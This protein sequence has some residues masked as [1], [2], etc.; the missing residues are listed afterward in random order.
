MNASTFIKVAL[1][2]QMQQI[3]DLGLWFHLSRL[4]PAGVDV[5][6]RVYFAGAP[7]M[8]D[9]NIFLPLREEDVWEKTYKTLFPKG[10][11]FYPTR[12]RFFS[13]YPNMFLTSAENEAHLHLTK[14]EKGV[15]FIHVPTW[16]SDFKAACTMVLAEIECG[17]I[18]DIEVL[19]MLET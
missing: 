12:Q 4:M 14:D 8:Y 10:Y 18:E 9:G 19:K 6:G 1:I 7:F 3:A 17:T 2:D 11:E 16:F 5:L 15:M 13:I